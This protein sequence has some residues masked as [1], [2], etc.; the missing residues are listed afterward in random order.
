MEATA[1][2]N[3]LSAADVVALLNTQAVF[4]LLLQLPYPITQQGAIDKLLDEN[5]IVRSNGHFYITYLGAL[6]FAKDLG[7]FGLE[8]KAMRVIKYKGTGK[9]HTEKEHWIAAGYGASFQQS[10]D[11]VL[12]QLPSNEVI[13]IAMR[14]T[15]HLYPPL[16]VRELLANAMIHQDINEKGT[17]LSVEIFDDRMEISNPGEPALDPTRFID[18]YNARNPL[19]ASAMRRMGYCE[20]KGSGIDKVISG[21]EAY[22]LPAPDFRIKPN[23]TIS[24]LFAP[25]ELR[26]MDKKDKIRAC[27]QHCCLMYVTNQKMSN[28]T[29]RS[30]FKVEKNNTASVS[31]IITDTLSA[32]LIKRDDL[33]NISRKNVRYIPYW[34]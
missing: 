34:A 33:E 17:F 4:D 19:L 14:K 11:Y 8:R 9:L 7:K 28:Q 27:Y 29:L 32:E 5:L 2:P 24:V 26:D 13:E 21:C 6:L 22:Q 15:V 31:R 10:I 23:Q 20:E 25:K 18:G 30:R 12:G 16:A 3:A 1:L